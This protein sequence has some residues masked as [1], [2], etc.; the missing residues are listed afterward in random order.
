[1]ADLVNKLRLSPYR[2]IFWLGG[3]VRPGSVRDALFRAGELVEELAQLDRVGPSK[4][5]LVV[6]AGVSGLS[7]ACHALGAFASVDL[8][9]R[10]PKSYSPFEQCVIREV[11]PTSFDYPQD[12]FPIA[13]FPHDA[14][15][16]LFEWE[17][18]RASGVWTQISDQ[19][20]E[21]S[22][23][24]GKKFRAFYGS[25]I[26]EMK[27]DGQ[28][29]VLVKIHPR[30]QQQYEAVIVATG[31]G[32][33]RRR[34]EPDPRFEGY[35][36]FDNDAIFLRNYHG[37]APKV[38]L[39]GGGD[40]SLVDFV[41]LITGR[42]KVAPSLQE[43][44][45]EENSIDR[46]KQLA[47]DMWEEL[48][49][50]PPDLHETYDRLQLQMIQY[51]DQLW[52]VARIQEAVRGLI[53]RTAAQRPVVQICLECC[54]FGFAYLANRVLAQLVARHL[55]SNLAVE[56]GGLHPF[57]IGAAVVRIE[58]TDENHRC[59]PNDDSMAECAGVPH[60]VSFAASYCKSRQLSAYLAER[61]S[62]G[63]PSMRTFTDRFDEV[64]RFD[65]ILM[66]TGADYFAN[67]SG[68]PKS[69]EEACHNCGIRWDVPDF[70]TA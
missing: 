5:V 34:I 51:I 63:D 29:N 46:I 60:E 57:R 30:P 42:D 45:L 17:A 66:R 27:E 11:C 1:M 68:L 70:Y 12:H 22:A 36:Y 18:D 19:F 64:V 52:S 7:A 23:L 37:N 15:E 58:S 20:Q 2:N 26:T 32:A 10:R 41:R 61:K 35:A 48:H 62:H 49:R 50:G 56:N 24:A 16:T 13:R 3:E 59:H 8:C 31:I 54:H 44:G 53:N 55:A 38:L 14:T 39:V 9:E 21:L 40:G 28:Q 6:G 69:I 25:E 33:L 65:R 47:R 67:G 4:R 43:L